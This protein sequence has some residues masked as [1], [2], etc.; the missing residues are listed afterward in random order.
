[1]TKERLRV[2]NEL[3]KN[4]IK[5]ETLYN[6]NPRNDKQM[7]FA[8]NNKVPFVIFIGENEVKENKIKVKVYF[9]F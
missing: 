5:A 7:D 6:E 3:W 1:M 8:T 4:E 9:S 2:L